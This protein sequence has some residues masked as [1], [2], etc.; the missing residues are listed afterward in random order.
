MVNKRVRIIVEMFVFSVFAILSI[1]LIN[2]FQGSSDSYS[3][4]NTVGSLAEGNSTST[5]FSQRIIGGIIRVGIYISDTFS[6][7]FGILGSAKNLAINITFPTHNS[8]VVR[9][10]DEATG[11][12][13]KS[14]ILN[15]INITARVYE[16][17]TVD[18]FRGARCFFFEHKDLFGNSSTNA[19][20]HCFINYTKS[21]F[22][23]GQKNISVNYTIDTSD[24][25]DVN[26]SQVNFSIVRYVTTLSMSNFGS[27]LQSPTGGSAYSNG[28]VAVLNITIEK[29]NS[30]GTFLYDPQNITANATNQGETIYNLGRFLYPYSLGPSLNPHNRIIRLSKGNYSANITVN[31]SFGSKIRW[32]VVS[33]DN[34][35]L[36]YLSTAI[37]SDIDICKGDFG[38]YGSLSACSGGIQTRSRNDSTGCTQVETISCGSGS[39]SG[40]ASPPA[41]TP[42]WGSWSEWGNCINGEERRTRSDGCGNTETEVRECGCAPDWVCSDWNECSNPTI[43]EISAISLNEN[44]RFE[45]LKYTNSR[46]FE[47]LGFREELPPIK[48]EKNI[49]KNNLE[50]K[51]E[52][53][54]IKNPLDF[55]RDILNKLRGFTGFA[56][57]ETKCES[58]EDLGNKQCHPTKQSVYQECVEKKR[59]RFFGEVI[60]G[61]RNNNCA[62]GMICSGEGNCVCNPQNY[63]DTEG[64][65]TCSSINSYQIC[66]KDE[67]S[68]LSWS[69]NQRCNA[70]EV[71]SSGRCVSGSIEDSNVCNIDETKCVKN[72]VYICQPNRRGITNWIISQ[73]CN[74]GESCIEG[75]CIVNH[76][77]NDRQDFDEESID[78]GGS[79]E[80]CIKSICGNRALE[81]GETCDSDSK[82]CNIEGYRGTQTC[83]SDCLGYESC[84]ASEFCGDGILNGQEECDDGNNIEG[85]GCS[86]ICKIKIAESP[87]TNKILLDRGESISVSIN[88]GDQLS[89]TYEEFRDN[90]VILRITR[91][92]TPQSSEETEAHTIFVNS[93]EERKVSVTVTSD[94]ITKDIILGQTETFDFSTQIPP[95][96]AAG[97][98]GGSKRAGN[99]TIIGNGSQGEVFLSPEEPSQT[100]GCIDV[101]R[102]DTNE[103]KPNEIQQCIIGLILE[104][105]PQNNYL[106]IANGTKIYFSIKVSKGSTDRISVNWFIGSLFINGDSGLE[107]VESNFDHIFTRNQKIKGEVVV[108][109]STQN[110]IWQVTINPDAIPNCEE[111]WSCEWS[112]CDL[113][114]YKYS[115]E[116][117]DLKSC[118][119]NVFRPTKKTCNC[120][121]D[122]KCDEWSIC[123]INYNLEDIL[124]GNPT[125]NGKQERT[126]KEQKGCEDEKP[127]LIEKQECS[128]A[129][130][131]KTKKTEWCF[132]EYIE[133]YDVKTNKLVSRF[134][135]RVIE[136]IKKIDV[137][138]LVTEFEGVCSYC[139]DQ[140]KNF[141]EIDVD[142]GGN[143]QPCSS[144]KRYVNYIIYIKWILWTILTILIIYFIYSSKIKLIEIHRKIGEVDEKLTKE[145]IIKRIKAFRLPSIKLRKELKVPSTKSYAS[146]RAKLREWK[147]KGY[148]G[149]IT[150]ERKLETLVAKRIRKSEEIREAE[151]LERYKKKLQKQRE[152]EARKRERE[153]IKEQKK[154]EKEK[155][156]ELKKRGRRFTLKRIN[157]RVSSFI[158]NA[159]HKIAEKR[160]ERKRRK[161]VKKEA[162]IIKKRI[163]KK[164]ISMGEL[165][166]L[167]N[168][169]REWK[170]KGY[171]NAT[172]LQRRLDEY[173][174]RNPLK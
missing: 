85:D 147:E 21:S 42:S 130:D 35:Y 89:V 63:C 152:K 9:G 8:D 125:I 7:R 94:P 120:I 50:I 5:D 6:G 13:E 1:A 97:G 164:E 28:S 105:S 4:D 41:C 114:G 107:S 146:I 115:K 22:G 34:D 17:G 82:S 91:I 172:K 104:Y 58:S 121:P 14:G 136:G 66:Q 149:T 54:L 131:I 174:G 39:G 106:I 126:C 18:G 65:R 12:D 142:C 159:K 73:R 90:K 24:I 122:Y 98:G 87:P 86:V 33:S 59:L 169:L 166:G 157:S 138:F 173:E 148:Y 81:E 116:C 47:Y 83:K 144:T 132:E 140:V 129:R 69:N 101:N 27:G 113:S 99:R 46:N 137:G 124:H 119:T 45:N 15:S 165:T 11:E 79:C 2:A 48:I 109:N 112:Q 51:Y 102:C 76:C 10:N 168:K 56:V 139:F 160:V 123:Q 75:I 26:E 60:I 134:K 67:N 61:W 92:A 163:K 70:G 135:E 143:C 111:D 53:A 118:G 23:V 117:K 154:F 68:C 133:I 57:I 29:I 43:S 151:K 71:C 74:Q 88:K 80:E 141:D 95:S 36:T 150:L 161:T 110:I 167:R 38:D 77:L 93:I 55:F 170:E 171:Y 155:L 44:L 100:R 128:L 108:G 62:S 64:S 84:V 78:C 162:K 19:S 31:Y 158:T 145:I 30:S 103:G 40:G 153:I 3:T 25:K 72:S 20:G 96:D 37:H 32:D 16:N 127:F 52:R 49:Y 156:K